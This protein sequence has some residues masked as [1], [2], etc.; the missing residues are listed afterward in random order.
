MHPESSATD[1]IASA[2]FHHSCLPT[3]LQGWQAKGQS[4]KT[5][6]LLKMNPSEQDHFGN[7][8]CTL[9]PALLFIKSMRA[10]LAGST[11][12]VPLDHILEHVGNTPRIFLHQHADQRHLVIVGVRGVEHIS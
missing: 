4:I 5:H 10:T 3:R 12:H 7:G 9:E 6:Q 8:V 2:T 11:C 1:F